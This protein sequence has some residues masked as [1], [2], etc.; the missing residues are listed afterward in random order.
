MP[1]LGRAEPRRSLIASGIVASAGTDSRD[2]LCAVSE[3]GAENGAGE[4]GADRYFAAGDTNLSTGPIGIWARER[5]R[6]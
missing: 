4:R 1:F 5:G 6:P 3:I 2:V